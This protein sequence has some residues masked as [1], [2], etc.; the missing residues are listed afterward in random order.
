MYWVRPAVL[1]VEELNLL[2]EQC[3]A[4]VVAFQC[5]LLEKDVM[6]LH[7]KYGMVNPM[8]ADIPKPEMNEPTYCRIEM[9]HNEAQCSTTILP[10]V[11]KLDELL[12][13]RHSI[14]LNEIL[15]YLLSCNRCRAMCYYHWET[16]G[17]QPYLVIQSSQEEQYMIESQNLLTYVKST[18]VEISSALQYLGIIEMWRNPNEDDDEIEHDWYSSDTQDF[19]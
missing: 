3:T 6:P 15:I 8:L 5:A 13:P 12:F 9:T 17:I 4:E 18:G 2:V 14:L 7:L 16:E 19:F 10:I 1:D 11:L